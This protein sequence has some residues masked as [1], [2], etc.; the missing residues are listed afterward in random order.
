M[1]RHYAR[2]E[3]ALPGWG[4]R[5]RRDGRLPNPCRGVWSKSD[6]AVG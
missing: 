4:A 3:T 5:T 1:I 2:K 6:L